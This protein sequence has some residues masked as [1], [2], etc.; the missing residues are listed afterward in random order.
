RIQSSGS[1]ASEVLKRIEVAKTS[2]VQPDGE[3]LRQATRGVDMQHA[4]E[5]FAVLSK[6]PPN[7]A[8]NHLQFAIQDE[9]DVHRTV[10]AWRAWEMM[11][12]TGQEFAHTLLRQ[13]VRYCVDN[14]QR[15]QSKGSLPSAV[16]DLLPQLMEEF[17]LHS[18]IP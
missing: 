16:R 11:E 13:S 15:R 8:Y 12:I 9:V 17:G 10:L 7:E 18:K 1:N 14:E 5:L 6:A 2:G 3:M 4:E